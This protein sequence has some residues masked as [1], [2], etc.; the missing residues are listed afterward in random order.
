M[1]RCSR[2][3][4][5]ALFKTTCYGHLCEIAYIFCIGSALKCQ[6]PHSPI[7]QITWVNIQSQ[8]LYPGF[9]NLILP[10]PCAPKI[11]SLPA[12]HHSSPL[13]MTDLGITITHKPSYRG[14]HIFNIPYSRTL[15]YNHPLPPPLF[16]PFSRLPNQSKASVLHGRSNTAVT[17]PTT[18]CVGYALARPPYPRRV[19]ISVCYPG[20][21]VPPRGMT[22]P[23]PPTPDSLDSNCSFFPLTILSAEITDPSCVFFSS[24]FFRLGTAE[25]EFRCCC[26]VYW[27]SKSTRLCCPPHIKRRF[28]LFGF[29]QLPAS[30]VANMFVDSVNDKSAPPATPP[31]MNW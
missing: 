4:G 14:S 29:K 24:F 9:P 23:N 1:V 2:P 18:C 22:S 5:E 30:P 16:S 25:S 27:R 21:K 12:T 3:R 6:P 20:T 26:L 31:A 28:F 11:D 13:P 8:G 19:P 17:S 15:I 7:C 10:I